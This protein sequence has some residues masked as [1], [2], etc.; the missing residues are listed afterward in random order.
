MPAR[1]RL[2]GVMETPSRIAIRSSLALMWKW[3]V[4]RVV[5]R[6]AGA[7]PPGCSLEPVRPILEPSSEWPRSR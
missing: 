2:N 5:R 6:R 7:P 3:P 4:R 1:S